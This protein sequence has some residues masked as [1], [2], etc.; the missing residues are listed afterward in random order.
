ML[1]YRVAGLTVAM[2][3]F[4]R[5]YRQAK[6]YLFDTESVPDIFID[7]DWHKTKIRYPHLSDEDCEYIV[8]GA[9]FYRQ[10]LSFNGFMLHSSAVVV[11][12]KAYLFSA[13]SGTGKSTHTELWLKLFGERAFILNDDKPAL[14]LEDGVWYAYGTPWSG[15][16]D[17]STNVRV[18]V[19]GIAILDRNED[20]FIEPF[21]GIE[22]IEHIIRQSNRPRA[23]ECRIQ[24][25]QLLDE[26][27]TRVP[28]WRLRCN[29]DLE[30]AKISYETMSGTKLEANE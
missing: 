14:R 12:G 3:T 19:A 8:T 27:M 9:S 29:M 17:M 10:L 5:T 15:K 28:I 26:L 6:P 4:G 16:Y 30:S 2:D 25:L 23:A 20:N 7:T 21:G 18:P 13:N 24:L 1:H 22:A 11:D